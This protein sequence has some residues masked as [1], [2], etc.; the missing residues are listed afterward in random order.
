MDHASGWVDRAHTAANAE[1]KAI[2]S[3]V[4]RDLC[5][6]SPVAPLA[7]LFLAR[8]DPDTGRLDYCSAGHPPALLLR[9]DGQLELLSEGGPLLGVVAAATFD[10]GSVELGAGDLLLICSDGILES[11]NDAEEEF[12]M[13]VLRPNCAAHRA[14]L[15]MRCCFRCWARSR[16]SL[17]RAP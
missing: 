10:Q 17:L 8:L 14:A 4:N 11:F 12:G 13:S 3:G 9:A 15:P 6:M 1:P 2:V 7:S 5:R 16:I